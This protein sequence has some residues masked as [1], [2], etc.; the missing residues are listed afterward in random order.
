MLLFL[1]FCL[2][3]CG[4]VELYAGLNQKQA[5]EMAALLQQNGIEVTKRS[6][7]DKKNQTYAIFVDSAYFAESQ[8]I[9]NHHG[10]PEEQFLRVDDIFKKEGLIT[11]PLEERIRYIYALSQDVEETLAQID[12]VVTSRVHVVV[13]EDNPFSTQVTPSSASVFIRYI[14]GV[15][16]ENLKSEIKLIVHKSIEGLTYEKISVV[17]LPAVAAMASE[18]DVE[19]VSRWGVRVP[20]SSVGPLRILVWSLLLMVLFFAGLALFLGW[21]LTVLLTED[22]DLDADEGDETKSRGA[23]AADVWSRI[24]TRLFGGAV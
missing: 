6:N 8:G 20:E 15:G 22:D 24:R 5:N 3:G 11:S 18:D 7:K 12:G 16:I 2:A 17:M 21:R 19:W 13:P 14:P 10:L 9:L 4:E 23:R 1:V